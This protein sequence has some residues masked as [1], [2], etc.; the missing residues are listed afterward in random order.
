[1][2]TH[3][4]PTNL[5]DKFRV[6]FG[7]ELSWEEILSQYPHM[8]EPEHEMNGINPE[9]CLSFYYSKNI[10]SGIYD[11]RDEDAEMD[12]IER[13]QIDLQV[14]SEGENCEDQTKRKQMEELIEYLETNN[15]TELID[16][17]ITTCKQE[18]KKKKKERRLE[19]LNN[20][21]EL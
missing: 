12:I 1:M 7:I 8:N 15:E 9:D 17:E 13:L 3:N 21:Q 20:R 5:S 2:L 11:F 16:P 10:L 6:P 4:Q 18:N 19:R 14:I